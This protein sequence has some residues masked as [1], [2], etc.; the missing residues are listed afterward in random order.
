[1]FCRV[2]CFIFICFFLFYSLS[3]LL[4]DTIH[5]RSTACFDWGESRRER[6]R[7]GVKQLQQNTFTDLESSKFN[8]LFSHLQF[9]KKGMHMPDLNRNALCVLSYTLWIA[10]ETE[11]HKG[12][13]VMATFHNFLSFLVQ[14]TS[15]DLGVAGRL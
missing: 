7:R 14:A 1:M 10:S 3:T 9:Q 8:F 15:T 5:I 12:F 4:K 2:L 13:R 6:E 11:S